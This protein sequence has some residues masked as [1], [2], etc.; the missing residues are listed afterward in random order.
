MFWFLASR[1][2]LDAISATQKKK[3]P[4]LISSVLAMFD[5]FVEINLYQLQ[6]PFIDEFKK[7]NHDLN[8]TQ[9]EL[10]ALHHRSG[11]LL[12]AIV[13][14]VLCVVLALAMANTFKVHLVAIATAYVVGGLRL[15]PSINK[16]MAGVLQIKTNQFV[17][18]ELMEHL[19]L[20]DLQHH[21]HPA[22]LPI[23]EPL[24]VKNVTFQ[25]P[26]RNVLMHDVN[27]RIEPGEKV[28]LVGVSGAGKSS[29][30]MLLLGFLKPTA[31]SFEMN[32]INS[33]YQKWKS[34]FAFVP[35]NPILFPG[36]I[37]SN[38]CL[39][40]SE[41]DASLQRAERAL[42]QVGLWN[43]VNELPQGIH[44][45]IGPNG[46]QISGGQRQRLAMARAL[47]MERSI[48]VMD[49]PTAQLDAHAAEQLIQL[50]TQL[51][52]T[53]ILATH[54]LHLLT[55]FDV[56]YEIKNKTVSIVQ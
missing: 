11:R 13:G 19:S 43:W 25:Y 48:I 31:G 34:L 37:A 56:V 18:H 14:I 52:I 39:H 50:V 10:H 9:V 54:Q 41:D 29:F 1:K 21:L 2:K 15:I 42:H 35:Q 30:L 7:T 40:N 32:E 28:A 16:M 49:E 46:I 45:S 38:I 27:L 51:P 26:G 44:T 8:Q 3:Y 53:V 12:E 20:I 5:A 24:H 36:S 55:R 23:D 22:V 6:K 33:H 4:E 17:Q 47:F